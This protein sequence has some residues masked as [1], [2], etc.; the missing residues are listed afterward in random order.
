MLQLLHVGGHDGHH[1]SFANTTCGAE[2]DAVHRVD[3][4]HEPSQ[5]GPLDGA[6]D[7]DVDWCRSVDSTATIA[8]RSVGWSNGAVI[9][10]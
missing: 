5:S 7:V 2:H 10:R 4:N 1:G 3:L 9:L 8:A 6:E